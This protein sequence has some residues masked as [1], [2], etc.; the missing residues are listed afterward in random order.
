MEQA[1]LK[2]YNPENN[3]RKCKKCTNWKD[4]SQFSTRVSKLKKNIQYREVCKECSVNNIRNTKY[5]TPSYRKALRVIDSRKIMLSHAKKRALE[6][7]LECTITVNDIIIPNIC[8]FL[9]IPI[10][11]CTSEISGR[12]GPCDN[13]PSLDRLDNTKGYIPGN[14]L[15]VSFRANS[16]KKD[17][18]IEELE[19]LLKNLK[20]VLYKSGELLELH[21][22]NMD[23]QQPSLE[24]NAL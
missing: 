10:F 11:V 5:S 12:H 7:G 9:Q 19:L 8:P 18:S 23:N 24:L 6:K 2:N 16:L 17:A 14:V 15:V 20:M 3:T 4:L 21:Q 13:S 1:K 22:T